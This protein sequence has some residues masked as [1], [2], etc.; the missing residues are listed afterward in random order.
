MKS[1]LNQQ[2]GVVRCA[3]F[4]TNLPHANQTHTLPS[5]PPTAPSPYYHLI[6]QNSF[7]VRS[8]SDLSSCNTLGEVG[9]PKLVCLLWSLVHTERSPWSQFHCVFLLL[10]HTKHN[11]LWDADCF[12]LINNMYWPSG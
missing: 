8:E 3:L 6:F 12:C 10:F 4:Y 11:A 2:V 9:F 1:E 7:G 5:K